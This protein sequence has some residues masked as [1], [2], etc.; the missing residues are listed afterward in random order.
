M[1]DD[2]PKCIKCGFETAKQPAPAAQKKVPQ[3]F[4]GVA[5]FAF[6]PK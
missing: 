6:A 1:P 5:Q 2:V 4:D 3:A